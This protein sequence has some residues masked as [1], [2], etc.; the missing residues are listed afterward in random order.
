MGELAP[1]TAGPAALRQREPSQ[2]YDRLKQMI[3][4]NSLA[5][6]PFILQEELAD[7]LGVSRTP[8]REA[9]IRLQNEGLVEMRPRHGVRVLAISVAAMREIYAVLT[10]LEALAARTAAERGLSRREI[11][12]LMRAVDDM[13]VALARDDLDAWAEA[14][15]RFHRLLV[16]CSAN[17]RLIGM[18][19]T[20][21]DQAHRA[22]H[23]TL[24]LRPKPIASN[25]DH[26]AVV[27]AIVAGDAAEAYRVHERHRRLSGAAL[28]DI[29]E[30]LEIDA[31]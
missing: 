2:I 5:P 17:M 1:Q 26:R 14:D 20:V 8:V 19:A 3:L 10:A 16:E 24:R 29:L 18:V 4:D 22:R 11:A 25:A 30:R 6:G 31:L 9:L 21:V 7:R 28:I 27:D 15:G 23:T 12:L 13:D